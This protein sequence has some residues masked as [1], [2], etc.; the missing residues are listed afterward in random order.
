MVEEMLGIGFGT[1]ASE[2]SIPGIC[3][4]SEA[5]SKAAKRMEV[6]DIEFEVGLDDMA[7]IEEE[8]ELTQFPPKILTEI[9]LLGGIVEDSVGIPVALM[10]TYDGLVVGEAVFVASGVRLMN[11][12][13]A[14]SISLIIFVVT[15]ALVNGGVLLAGA[16][17]VSIM[18]D[19]WMRVRVTGPTAAG[20]VEA[21]PPS[22]ATTE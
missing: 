7:S 18:S 19:V 8:N 6:V 15:L 1:C 14:G 3:V 11:T 9:W 5:R 10:T 4:A 21:E 22:T 12:V 16:V 17:T 20:V 2:C 13:C